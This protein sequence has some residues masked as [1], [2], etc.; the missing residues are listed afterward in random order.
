[1]K[2]IYQLL[3]NKFVLFTKIELIR[4]RGRFS[5][6]LL[7]DFSENRKSVHFVHRCNTINTGDLQCGYYKYFLTRF[8]NFNC[9]VHD[10]NSVDYSIIRYND[11]VL[12]GGGGLLNNLSTWNY[13]INRLGRISKTAVIWSAGFNMH[14]DRKVK[15]EIDFR[16]FRLIAIR[17]FGHSSGFEYVPCAT[18]MMPELLLDYDIKR[19][20][21]VVSHGSIALPEHLLRYESISNEYSAKDMVE[22]IG[23]SEIVLTN[24]FH[25][26]YWA[27][28]MQKKCIVVSPFS[29]KFKFLK[30]PPVSYS[31]DLDFDIS[32]T[33]I[34]PDA[35]SDSKALVN[36]FVNKLIT[37]ITSDV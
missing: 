37:I 35:L 20:I 36:G 19:K 13:T 30:F 28:L 9:Y 3:V 8:S 32:Q 4:T 25:V 2:N 11:V 16:N 33:K 15:Y 22:F 6:K 29:E 27:T 23:S 26:I 7:T 17:D 18:C 1:M 5:A 34:Y 10:L 31:G 12:V 24:S 21:G 14:V